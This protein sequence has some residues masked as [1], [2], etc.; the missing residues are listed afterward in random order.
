MTVKP[1][2]PEETE[3]LLRLAAACLRR[4]QILIEAW[5]ADLD[6]PEDGRQDWL[7]ACAVWDEFDTELE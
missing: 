5:P 4:I 3:A 2:T 6:V 7:E 1:L